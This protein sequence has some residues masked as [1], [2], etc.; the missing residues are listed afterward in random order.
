MTRSKLYVIVRALNLLT[1]WASYI[2]N[3]S[4]YTGYR[5]HLSKKGKAKLADLIILNLYNVLCK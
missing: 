4:L 3:G 5:V 2:D 1:F